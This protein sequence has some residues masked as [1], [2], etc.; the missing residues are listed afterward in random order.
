ME[1]FQQGTRLVAVYG[2]DEAARRAVRAALDAGLPQHAVRVAHHDD[3]VAAL[4]GEMHEELDRTLVVPAG[5]PATKGMVK[6]S[7]LITI[8][9]AILG[10]LVLSPLALFEWFGLSR[11]MVLVV[12]LITGALMGATAGFLIG[13]PVGARGPAEPT[14]TR[15]GITVGFASDDEQ[16]ADA[17]P[18]ED[19]IRLD[20]IGP[21]GRPL[22]MVETEERQVEGGIVEDLADR[23]QQTEGDWSDVRGDPEVELRDPDERTHP[24]RPGANRPGR[25]G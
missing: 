5:G 17:L 1:A 25:T 11:T 14:A 7:I 2:S 13:G 24:D 9:A 15:R 18:R 12:V 3:D 22:G 6:G 16:L 4:R 10:A 21:D 8:G 23:F 19:L 20:R